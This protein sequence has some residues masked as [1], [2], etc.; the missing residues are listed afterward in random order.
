MKPKRKT[1]GQIAFEAEHLRSSHFEDAQPNVQA[2]YERMALAVA[3]EV[4]R[5]LKKYDGNACFPII[6][7][8]K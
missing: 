5:R 3:K 2:S 4:L 8:I 1:L 7:H 6:S